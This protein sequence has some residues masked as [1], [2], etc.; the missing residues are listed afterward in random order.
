MAMRIKA[1]AVPFA[2][3]K[4]YARSVSGLSMAVSVRSS[5]V[6]VFGKVHFN[7][8]PTD[9]TVLVGYQPLIDAVLVE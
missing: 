5:Y 3:I 9:G 6:V 2:I 8:Y 4:P 7:I 1:T